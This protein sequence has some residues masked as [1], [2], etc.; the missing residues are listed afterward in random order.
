VTTYDPEFEIPSEF[1]D[2]DT[3]STWVP[4]TPERAK[5]TQETAYPEWVEQSGNVAYERF[6]YDAYVKA[7][8]R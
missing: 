3:V 5:V 6:L 1:F 4:L 7:G 2:H 8:N